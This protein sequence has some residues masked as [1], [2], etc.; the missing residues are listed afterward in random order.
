MMK[1]RLFLA[2]PTP[3]GDGRC[4]L[5]LRCLHSGKLTSGNE[6]I[7]KIIKRERT[8]DAD[9]AGNCQKKKEKEG[10]N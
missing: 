2:H 8:E 5:Y 10:D 9:R 3:S 1:D 7:K 6:I 4:A